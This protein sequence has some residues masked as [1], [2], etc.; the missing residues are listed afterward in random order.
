MKSLMT[1]SLVYTV[2]AGAV[3]GTVFVG[4][5]DAGDRRGPK[6]HAVAEG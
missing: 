3:L 5:A 4:R 6:H 1:K 2:L